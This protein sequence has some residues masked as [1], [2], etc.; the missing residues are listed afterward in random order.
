MIKKKHHYVSQFYL[1]SWTNEKERLF[2][3]INNKILPMRT[4][5][6][7]NSNYFYR[8]D[9]ISDSEKELL[10]QLSKKLVGPMK[11][12]IETIVLGFN[13]LHKLLSASEFEDQLRNSD[14]FKKLQSNLA[15]DLYCIIEELGSTA[16]NH[17]KDKQYKKIGILEYTDIVRFVT[18]Q[19]VRTKAVKEKTEDAELIS[20]LESRD[21]NF[22]T[23]HIISSIIIAEQ[24]SIRLIEKLYTLEI[25]NNKTD[26][27]LITNDNP[28]KNLNNVSKIDV[29]IYIPISPNQAIFIR[30]SNITEEDKKKIKSTKVD[31]LS[32]SQ[33]Y[34]SISETSDEDLIKSLNRTTWSNKEFSAYSLLRNDLAV[35]SS[36]SELATA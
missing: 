28:A 17:V 1:D 18:Y 7:A 19:L 27:N 8:I 21:I 13:F 12:A 29:N 25:L 14:E 26:I 30:P 15:E 36:N 2:A 22:D 24:L 6:V 3:L 4:K 23:Y 20:R 10:L 31:D 9:S 5:E 35:Y 33:Y 34:L 32:K 16:L 11:E